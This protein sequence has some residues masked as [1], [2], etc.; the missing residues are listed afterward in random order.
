[1]V[2]IKG[3]RQKIEAAFNYRVTRI[4]DDTSCWPFDS[5]TSSMGYPRFRGTR[6][7]KYAWWL[8]AGDTDGKFVLHTCDNRY[9]VR[10][11]PVG[12]YIVSGKEFISHGH[13]F[14]GTAKDNTTDMISKGRAGWSNKPHLWTKGEEQHY[15]K[16]SI[17][18]VKDIRE[19]WANGASVISLTEHYNF[20]TT[21]SIYII[22]KQES[23]RHVNGPSY[24]E[25][26]R[27]RAKILGPS[28]NT[29]PCIMCGDTNRPCEALGLCERC[30]KK[31]TRRKN[32][33]HDGKAIYHHHAKLTLEQVNFIRL[34]KG[35]ISGT[36]LARQFQIS[37]S[38]I[39]KIQNN[40]AW[41]SI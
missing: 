28:I 9:C 3:D 25:L 33:G 2:V 12:I 20:A 10:N 15:A 27:T 32:G 6:A 34:N 37:S 31:E 11:E 39:S 1:M 26:S 21:R 36:Q 14:I 8:V 17:N 4:A 29:G 18:D 22:L 7:S 16:I 41:T 19:Q 24:E 13:L 23:W 30:Y 38:T 5:Y 40:H 35:I